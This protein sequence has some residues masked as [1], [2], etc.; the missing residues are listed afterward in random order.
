M[1]GFGCLNPAVKIM[2]SIVDCKHAR[3]KLMISVHI[4]FVNCTVDIVDS[5]SLMH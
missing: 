3:A 5:T 1:V 2:G 4:C